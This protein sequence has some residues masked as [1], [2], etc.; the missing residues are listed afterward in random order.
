MPFFFGTVRRSGAP[1][2]MNVLDD[3]ALVSNEYASSLFLLRMCLM[4]EY[5]QSVKSMLSLPL[6]SICAVAV[7]ASVFFSTSMSSKMSYRLTV[8]AL[9]SIMTAFLG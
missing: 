1:C 7:T 2:R 3:F 5:F 9:V 4:S 6:K 8:G